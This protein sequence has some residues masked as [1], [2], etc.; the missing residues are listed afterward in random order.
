ML[1]LE[2][3]SKA[4][5]GTDGFCAYICWC[6]ELA[7]DCSESSGYDVLP[8]IAPICDMLHFFMCLSYSQFWDPRH[9]FK[10]HW[11]RSHINFVASQ[12]ACIRVEREVGTTYLFLSSA[13]RWPNWGASTVITSA[14]YP[15]R[16]APTHQSTV[17]HPVLN[18]WCTEG[19]TYLYPSDKPQGQTFSETVLSQCQGLCKSM[20]CQTVSF[21]TIECYMSSDPK[22][23]Y[24]RHL[25]LQKCW[26]RW[27]RM[28]C[29]K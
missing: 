14:S 17:L 9:W 12:S 11:G 26:A 15:A 4:D 22:P 19:D 20:S 1:H 24:F 29:T 25:V 10:I 16:S 28:H 23:S 21:P 13:S 18:M 5:K 8:G 7:V 3:C 2:A 6:C 27:A